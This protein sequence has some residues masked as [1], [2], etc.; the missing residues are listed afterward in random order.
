MPCGTAE[1]ADL[2]PGVERV[3]PANVSAV[4]LLVVGHAA[5]DA[6]CLGAASA[7]TERRVVVLGYV[8]R[9][10]GVERFQSSQS[11]DQMP[12]S[13]SRAVCSAAS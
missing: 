10:V 11:A 12:A 2:A 6:S 5:G 7:P 13:V 4:P 3:A 9:R 1:R 8:G